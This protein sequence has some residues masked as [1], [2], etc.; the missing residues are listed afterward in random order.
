MAIAE[1]TV[2]DN[3]ITVNVEGA[4]LLA[5][6]VA[7]AT[8]A[9]AT[10]TT[11]AAEAAASAAD[12]AD[13][14]QQAAD[15][16]NP[17]TVT[18]RYGPLALGT[19]IA[20]FPANYSWVLGQ[21]ARRTT[22]DEIGLTV[23]A[24]GSGAVSFFVAT[25]DPEIEP[26]DFVSE[27][28]L[29]A[30]SST[31]TKI[32][33]GLALPEV[34]PGQFFGLTIPAGGPTVRRRSGRTYQRTPA[35]TSG[36]ATFSVAPGLDAYVLTSEPSYA[37]E[38][39]DLSPEVQAMLSVAPASAESQT[40][41]SG[42]EGQ[43]TSATTGYSADSTVF[44]AAAEYA[45][46]LT[47]LKFRVNAL[48]NGLTNVMV[49]RGDVVTG[50]PTVVYEEALPTI[51]SIGEAS[52]TATTD[53]GPFFLMR[54]DLVCVVSQ[55]GGPT[56]GTIETS[57]ADTFYSVLNNSPYQGN[58]AAFTTTA[59]RIAAARFSQSVLSLAMLVPAPPMMWDIFLLAGQSNM[60]G[61]ALAGETPIKPG[62]AK[63]WYSGALTDLTDDPVGAANTGSMCPAFAAEY[64]R[65]TGRGVI[66]VPAAVLGSGLQSV[67]GGG[68]GVSNT[69]SAAAG[70]GG[71]A[72]RVA[73]ITALNA[74]KAEATSAGLAWQFA[75][76]LWCQG[77][78]D[79]DAIGTSVVGASKAGY[80]AEF[81][82]L[83]AYFEA[84]TF[85]A[86]GKMPM[87][88]IRTG[89]RSPNS[90]AYISAYQDIRD[91][92]DTCARTLPGVFM[93]FTGAV[94][95]LTRNMM[96]DTYHWNQAAQDEVGVSVAMVASARCVGCA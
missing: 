56:L 2:V 52:F 78:A 76:V 62:I 30:I 29:S 34:Q 48:G 40:L 23:A 57:T 72:Y 73:A 96:Q 33:T 74:A 39:E 18:R 64:Y 19:N 51:G 95:F 63:Q 16:I 83:L 70:S 86:A 15:V 43:L 44:I 41:W 47:G 32:W 85:N 82:T 4:T 89:T 37:V 46:Y 68:S 26:T 66:F 79:G 49:M 8:A 59:N 55:I 60:V 94:N 61:L 9:A 87:L 54:G 28:A 24:V 36:S 45:G 5:P 77:E 80:V 67:A 3:A 14:V 65:R 25:G 21:A 75:G 91:A 20:D 13:T 88:I 92:Q 84:Q 7:S 58:K 35:F 71:A 12:A 31:G 50:R 1:V 69:W 38:L 22:I 11:K 42:Y 53:F 6:L 27:T 17:A 93:A 81:T 90:G 10:A